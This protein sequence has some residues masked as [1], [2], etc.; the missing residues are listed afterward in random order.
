MHCVWICI[1]IVDI[2]TKRKE[3][4][5]NLLELLG[6]LKSFENFATS[7]FANRPLSANWNYPAAK[8]RNIRA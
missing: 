2:W 3:T 7:H 6:S 8:S 5:E 1:I 4:E